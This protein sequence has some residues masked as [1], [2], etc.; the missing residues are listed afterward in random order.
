ME[1]KTCEAYVLAEIDDLKAERDALKLQVE[2]ERK[3]VDSWA[4]LWLDEYNRAE[5]LQSELDRAVEQMAELESQMERVCDRYNALSRESVGSF[6]KD[7][8][9]V[10]IGGEDGD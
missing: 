3:R 8:E 2:A 10:K 6:V 9:P 5:K 1:I 7:F 4:T